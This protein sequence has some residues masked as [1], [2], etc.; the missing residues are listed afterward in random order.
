MMSVAVRERT[1]SSFYKCDLP[2]KALHIGAIN[3][4]PKYRGKGYGSDFI[5]FAKRESYKQG[6]DGKVSLVAYFPGRAPHLFYYKKGFITPD[7]K[8]N[9]YFDNCIKTGQTFS[10]FSA[11]DMFLP[12]KKEHFVSE[13]VFV[14]DSKPQTFVG[15]LFKQIVGFLFG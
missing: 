13:G 4:F 2:Y 7:K 15:K 5:K 10:D 1:S 11:Q 6:C 8:L 3:I 12:L 14:V 9:D